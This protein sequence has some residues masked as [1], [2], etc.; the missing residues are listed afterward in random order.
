MSELG[1]MNKLLS[2]IAEHLKAGTK[3]EKRKAVV[4]LHQLASIATT[5]GF[6]IGPSH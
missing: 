6:T 4:K 5:M 2:E 1:E 3:S